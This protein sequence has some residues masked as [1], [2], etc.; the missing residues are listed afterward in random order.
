MTSTDGSIRLWKYKLQWGHGEFAV[1]DRRR[2]GGQ[3]AQ[4]PRFNGAT[5]S[6]PWMTPDAGVISTVDLQLQWGHGEFAVDDLLRGPR[7][8]RGEPA[9]MG[10]RR[11]RRG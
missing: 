5:A 2:P 8:R 10:P 4:P 7:V 6:S 1:D 9:S 3:G 11:V